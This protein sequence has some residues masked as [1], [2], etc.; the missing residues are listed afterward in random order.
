MAEAI[1]RIVGRGEDR[2]MALDPK[3]VVVGRSGKCDITLEDDK[4]SRRHARIFQDPFGRWLIQDLG[5][6]NGVKVDGERV[7][8]CALIPGRKVQV[9]P[10]VLMLAEEVT[11]EIPQDPNVTDSITASVAEDSSSQVVHAADRAEARLSR[12]RLKWLT[13]IADQLVGLSDPSFLYRELC[14]S[15]ARTSGTAAV[16]VRLAESEEL[17]QILACHIGGGDEYASLDAAG[18]L[19]LSRRV[20]QA[21][22]A[23]KEAVMATDAEGADAPLGLTIADETKPRTVY[24]CPLI[25]AGGPLDALYVDM[26]SAQ[27]MPDTFD[28]FQ[29]VARQVILVRRSL[30]LARARAENEVLE[31]Q[32]STAREIQSQL[33]P[34]DL[35]EIG[36]VDLAIHYEPAMWVGG[37]Y[38]DV[39][40]LDDGRVAFAV[41]DVSGKGLPA[42]IAMANLQAALRSTTAFCNDLSSIVA[43]T[44]GLLGRNLPERMFVTLFVGLLEPQSGQLQYVNA[45]HLQPVVIDPQGGVSLLSEPSGPPIGVGDGPFETLQ[46]TLLPGTGLVLV[47][48]GITESASPGD[49]L[50]GMDRLTEML[51]SA[52]VGSAARLVERVVEAADD[53][54]DSAP[55]GDDVTVLALITGNHGEAP[56]A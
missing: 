11:G 35:D 15:I 56:S 41:G 18:T 23:G 45:G 28:F 4:V 42:A 46:Q 32:L 8:A 40:Q 6:R 37:D 12:G 36:G 29:A 51:G 31:H 22:R 47:T 52:P 17:P 27:T 26:P 13:A 55:Q 33:T 20:I 21:V 10:F 43:Q 16:V 30:L 48:D 49:E 50:F 34:R 53:F 9:G 7:D 24:C 19:P 3:G 44:N 39:W 2:K 38:C 1:V 5:S 14:R 54:R 25:D